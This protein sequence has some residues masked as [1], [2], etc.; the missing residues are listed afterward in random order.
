M[1]NAVTKRFELT[2]GTAQQIVRHGSKALFGRSVGRFRSTLTGPQFK[3]A[4]GLRVRA[5]GPRLL[6]SIC[7]SLTEGFD[8]RDLRKAERAGIM[9]TFCSRGE[10]Q[11]LA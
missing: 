4:P 3:A 6:A 5:A 9:T 2:L 7:G 8:T 11:P 10:D 1:N